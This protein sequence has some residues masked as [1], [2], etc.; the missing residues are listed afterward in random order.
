MQLSVSLRRPRKIISARAESLFTSSSTYTISTRKST[1]KHFLFL[2]KGCPS[3]AQLCALCVLLLAPQPLHCAP[4]PHQPRQ[5]R[6]QSAKRYYL[7]TYLF[8][9]DRVQKH[10]THANTLCITT[11]N[12]L[13]KPIYPPH[14]QRLS[15]P[16][17][18]RRNGRVDFAR[19]AFSVRTP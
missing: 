13:L 3:F 7:P 8:S 15:P 18:P 1:A 9:L 12:S 14:S 16:R 4:C 11:D 10:I 19:D 5:W 6:M 2:Q 17:A